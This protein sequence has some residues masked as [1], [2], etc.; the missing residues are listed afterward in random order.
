MTEAMERQTVEELFHALP[1]IRK[2]VFASL[3]EL[4]ASSNDETKAVLS[5]IEQTDKKSA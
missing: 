2:K 4:K 1:L 5:V 3:V